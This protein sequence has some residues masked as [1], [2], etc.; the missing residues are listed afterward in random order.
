MFC[1]MKLNQFGHKMPACATNNNMQPYNNRAMSTYNTNSNHNIV[2]GSNS[3]SGSGGI[4]SGHHMDLLVQEMQNLR[5]RL[6]MMETNNISNKASSHY[7]CENI[8]NSTY[9][10]QQCHGHHQQQQD[11]KVEA[12]MMPNNV[13]NANH[14]FMSSVSRGRHVAAA[15]YATTSSREFAS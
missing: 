13:T 8:N 5:W 15:R 10:Q 7:D 4:S 14:A 6:S 12:A 9:Q 11:V 3:N 2:D 1:V